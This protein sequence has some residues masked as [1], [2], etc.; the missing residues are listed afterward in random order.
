MVGGNG[1][2]ARCGRAEQV[3]TAIRH[4]LRSLSSGDVRGYSWLRSGLAEIGVVLRV[5]RRRYRYRRELA[6]LIGS[7]A[8]LIEDIGLSPEEAERERAKP[9]WR[10]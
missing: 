1:R 8:H 7:G 3:M 6:R 10:P 4:P 2:S 9:F 5:W